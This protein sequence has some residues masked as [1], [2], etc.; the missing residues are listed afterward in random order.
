MCGIKALRVNMN[1]L[2]TWDK[3]GQH[4]CSV[5]KSHSFVDKNKYVSGGRETGC[6]E[7]VEISLA[8]ILLAALLRG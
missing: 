1:N 4:T 8:Q 7:R 2:G 6:S 5:D 3:R